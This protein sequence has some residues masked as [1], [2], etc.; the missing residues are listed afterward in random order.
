[1]LLLLKTIAAPVNEELTGAF[2]FFRE[3][4]RDE[5][6]F[7]NLRPCFAPVSKKALGEKPG[8]SR[9]LP[10]KGR[11]QKHQQEKHQKH[12]KAA[13]PENRRGTSR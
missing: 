5:N 8:K 9:L 7:C 12:R 2:Y 3:R 1:M 6:F 11:L 13:V 4:E 10:K